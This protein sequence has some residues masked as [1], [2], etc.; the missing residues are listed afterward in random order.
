VRSFIAC[1]VVVRQ[2]S[3][4]YEGSILEQ[5]WVSSVATSAPSSQLGK[6]KYGVT[7]VD[8]EADDNNISAIPVWHS[9]CQCNNLTMTM[10]EANQTA[11]NS[12]PGNS[13]WVYHIASLPV[14]LSE[15]VGV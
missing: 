10:F 15:S 13:V 5:V 14:I 6:K 8:G 3:F 7:R 2:G 1:E 11:G 12:L 4:E 9:F